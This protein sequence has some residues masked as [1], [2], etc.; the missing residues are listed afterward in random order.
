MKFVVFGNG[1]CHPC[2]TFSASWQSLIF[3]GQICFWGWLQKQITGVLKI[4]NKGFPLAFCNNKSYVL[5]HFLWNQWPFN[6]FFGLLFF[7][8]LQS[9]YCSL[10][11][12]AAGLSLQL[13]ISPPEARIYWETLSIKYLSW[14]QKICQLRSFSPQGAGVQPSLH[15]LDSR[16]EPGVEPECS[17]DVPGQTGMLWEEGWDR[18][19]ATAIF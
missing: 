13:L 2:Q 4:F 6:I 18:E 1:L 14:T 15:R 16:G 8:H 5:Q 10:G 11:K 12:E 3:P 7:F 19:G 17:K 9:C